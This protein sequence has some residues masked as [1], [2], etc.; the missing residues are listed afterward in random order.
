MYVQVY[1]IIK[2]HNTKE[3]QLLASFIKIICIVN[4]QSLFD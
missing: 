3:I 2:T 1:P 4:K